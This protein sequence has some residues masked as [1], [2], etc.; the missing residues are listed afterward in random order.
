MATDPVTIE[1]LDDQMRAH[2]A[3]AGTQPLADW[4]GDMLPLI[5]SGNVEASATTDQWV[6]FESLDDGTVALSR[7]FV[8][9]GEDIENVV[10]TLRLT[11]TVPPREP[12]WGAIDGD[13]AVSGD[14]IRIDRVATSDWVAAVAVA[15]TNDAPAR[16]ITEVDFES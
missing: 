12:L 2:L 4:L 1:D 8:F 5:V 14:P 16:T 6:L 11:P 9:D 15:L 10:L 3:R 7:Y 13:D